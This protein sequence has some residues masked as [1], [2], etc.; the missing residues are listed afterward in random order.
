MNRLAMIRQVMGQAGF[1]LSRE[2]LGQVNPDIH[3][4]VTSLA[5][6]ERD[7]PD[8]RRTEAVAVELFPDV[9]LDI[10]YQADIF[11]RSRNGH[12]WPCLLHYYNDRLWH[13]IKALIDPKSSILY[14]LRLSKTGFPR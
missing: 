9:L 7:V 14:C 12:C 8:Q 10:L 5:K 11:W 1:R 4:F 6:T 2:R 13:E 3:K